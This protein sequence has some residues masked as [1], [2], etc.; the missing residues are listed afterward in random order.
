MFKSREPSVAVAANVESPTWPELSVSFARGKGELFPKRPT[1]TDLI[2][3]ERKKYPRGGNPISFLA[4]HH[5]SSRRRHQPPPTDTRPN[6]DMEHLR[7]ANDTRR[8]RYCI[9]IFALSTLGYCSLVSIA[10]VG[11]C[12][13]GFEP[14]FARIREISK[15]RTVKFDAWATCERRCT[16]CTYRHRWRACQAPV[17]S[18]AGGF[19]AAS[20]NP[21]H[22][23]PSLAVNRRYC[24]HRQAP[25]SG[26]HTHVEN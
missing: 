14:L 21:S 17:L 5:S 22:L 18:A 7:N 4:A 23:C 6:A 25:G 24:C 1:I 11:V 9:F 12:I 13:W 19:G 10:Y 15:F 20:A 16:Y 2:T 3:Q 26:R 8:R